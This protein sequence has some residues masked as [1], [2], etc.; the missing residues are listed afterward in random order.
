MQP[1]TEHRVSHSPATVRLEYLH[2]QA[3]LNNHSCGW[4]FLFTCS[5][6]GTFQEW[7]VNDTSLPVIYPGPVPMVSNK[8][9]SAFNYTSTVLSSS[10][11]AGG[12]LASILM[13]SVSSNV[14]LN[15]RCVTDTG[16]DV[17]SNRVMTSDTALQLN[18][19]N[20]IVTMNRLWENRH[21]VQGATTTCYM[22][23]VNFDYL[24]W[25]AHT[26]QLLLISE[27]NLGKQ[28]TLRAA[29]DNSL[30][31]QTIFFARSPKEIVALF[32]VMDSSVGE[33]SCRAGNTVVTSKEFRSKPT[34]SMPNT[35]YNL[36]TLS[37]SSA[38]AT[39]YS[40]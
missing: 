34:T 17:T 3:R 35:E 19:D 25:Q 6:T 39:N 27:F 21:L 8:D 4:D 36:N 30:R 11:E 20:G 26:D 31:L 22:C 23:G 40:K 38:A 12:Q 24:M 13:V 14:T 5:V 10:V 33:I 2:G 18:S 15:V 29:D 1:L 16:S 28:V 7:Y 37:P 32:L 9:L